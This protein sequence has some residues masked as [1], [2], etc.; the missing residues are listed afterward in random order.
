MNFLNKIIFVCLLVLSNIGFAQQD[1]LFSQYAFNTLSINPAYAG[2]KGVPT[3]VA[4]SRL[5]WVGFGDNSSVTHSAVFHTMAYEK[6]GMGLSLVQDNI[7]PTSQFFANIDASYHLQVSRR[8]HL[9]MGLKLGVAQYTTNFNDLNYRDDD[10]LLTGVI[11]DEKINIGAGAYYFSDKMYLGVSIPRLLES[12]FINN[13]QTYRRHYFFIGG[14]LT[15]LTPKLQFKPSVLFKYA[16]GTP[17][18]FDI[19]P[20]FI[21][22][23]NFLI[24]PNFRSNLDFGF[25]F[26]YWFIN[27]LKTG[28]AYDYPLGNLSGNTVGSFELMLGFDFKSNNKHKNVIEYSPRYF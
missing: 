24:G 3:A 7:G 5:Q 1:P 19:T 8:E 15:S 20:T 6:L 17:Y 14:Y 25:I 12:Q 23:D 10:V 2:T 28:L 4:I 26:Q 22:N 27:G 13:Y 9:A 16:E 11:S 18:S 21:I